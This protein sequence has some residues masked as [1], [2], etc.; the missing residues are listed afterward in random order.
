MFAVT[1]ARPGATEVLDWSPA[2]LDAAGAGDVVIDVAAAGINNADLLQR[3][4]L[5]R[6]P[7]GA[8]PVLGL[9]V[10]GVIAEVGADVT[11]WSV[12]DRVCA[13]LS[14]GGYAEQVVV[15][16]DLLLPV[17]DTLDLAEAAGLPEAVCTVYSNLA[18]TARLTSGQTL[19]VHG[20]GSG[21]G[22]IAI[23]W[24]KAL[25]ATVIVTA[26]SAGKLERCRDLGAD[27]TI[28]YRTDDF[29]ELTRAAT[30]GRGADVILDI[31]G[32]DYLARNLD[33]LADGGHLVV[34]G[35][36]GA[37]EPPRLNLGALMA[38]RATISAT[39]L[40]SRPHEQKATIVA[41]V[42][43]EV[44]PLIEAGRIRPVIDSVFDMRHAAE[45][46][47]LLEAGGAFGKVLLTPSPAH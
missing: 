46:H 34:I 30:Q 43:R 41:E 29:V 39:T 25:G 38:K 3:R 5:Y 28:D 31:V 33:A 4:G 26:G 42:R 37:A 7:A 44:W 18:M 45:G 9:E 20:G 12:G 32:A 24:A 17:P 6:V 27:V 35:N 22:T 16:A 10:S 36:R 11:G 13:L 47:D 1:F 8:S 23:Q 21:I 19:L 40:R 15:S 14:G 2:A